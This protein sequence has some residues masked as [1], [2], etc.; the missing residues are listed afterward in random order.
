MKPHTDILQAWERGE[1]LDV[2]GGMNFSGGRG[3]IPWVRPGEVG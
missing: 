2:G 1:N 3:L